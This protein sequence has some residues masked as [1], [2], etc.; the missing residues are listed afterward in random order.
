MPHSLQI[1]YGGYRKAA[2][3]PKGRRLA[4]VGLFTRDINLIPGVGRLSSC[5]RSACGAAGDAV[6]IHASTPTDP[7]LPDS[8]SQMLT[9]TNTRTV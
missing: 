4:P 1:N 8:R 2:S 9:L 7:G 6:R 3:Y 5:A